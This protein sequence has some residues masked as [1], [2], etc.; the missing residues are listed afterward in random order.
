MGGLRNAKH[1]RYCLERAAG[2]S[3]VDAYLTAFGTKSRARCYLLE[4]RPEVAARV[5]EL[6]DRV[7]TGTVEA[8]AVTRDG[9]IQLL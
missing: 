8:A 5:A 7:A 3:V 9:V 2:H 6:Q 1:E 4:K